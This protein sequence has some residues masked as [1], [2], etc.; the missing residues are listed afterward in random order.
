[1]LLSNSPYIGRPSQLSAE[2][3]NIERIR[4]S[5]QLSEELTMSARTQSGVLFL[6]STSMD[7]HL[8]G[9]DCPVVPGVVWGAVEAFPSPAYWAYRVITRR[10]AAPHAS[11]KL[12]NSL[13]EEL[14]ACLLGGHGL[15][16]QVGIA[17]FHHLKNLGAFTDI[18]PTEELL[19]EWLSMPLMVNGRDIRYRFARQKSKY[20]AAALEALLNY[21]PPVDSGKSLRNWL[22][23]LPGIGLKTASWIARNWL[24]ADDVAILDVHILRAG[25]LSGFLDP[26]LTVQRHYLQ[27]EQQFLDFSH[28]LGVRPSELDATIWLEM[29]SSPRLIQAMLRN[30]NDDKRTGPTRYVQ[31]S[32]SA[33]QETESYAH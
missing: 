30:N 16:A 14:G 21:V 26:A 29:M 4:R 9:P 13:P 17:A 1:M 5:N 15:P 22:I 11:Y 8:P 20:L 24:D 32:N 18:A 12:G 2:V 10:L 31:I 28:G 25:L 27:L 3:M 7:I 23:S 6:G 19:F 33:A